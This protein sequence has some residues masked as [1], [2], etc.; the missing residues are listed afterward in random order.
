M[1]R[2]EGDLPG[3]VFRVGPDL[4]RQRPGDSASPRPPTRGIVANRQPWRTRCLWPE[5]TAGREQNAFWVRSS[6]ER[7]KGAGKQKEPIREPYQTSGAPV[8]G[9]ENPI[10]SDCCETATKVQKASRAQSALPLLR[11]SSTRHSGGPPTNREDELRKPRKRSGA[12]RH[13][14]RSRHA[15]ADQF[16]RNTATAHSGTNWERKGGKA[17]LNRGDRS[18]RILP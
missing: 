17:R 14:D 1:A 2:G 4:G 16:I 10:L 11:L 5:S 18:P 8:N 6:G 12:R 7:G 3:D 9:S 13:D 15:P